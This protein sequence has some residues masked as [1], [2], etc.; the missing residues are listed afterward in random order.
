MPHFL[1]FYSSI[2]T[3]LTS[4]VH[5]DIITTKVVTNKIKEKGKWKNLYL[6]SYRNLD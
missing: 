3:N 1:S 4:I 5:Y 2:V 6:R